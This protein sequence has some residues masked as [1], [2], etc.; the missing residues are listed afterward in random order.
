AAGGDD[1]TA[2]HL[3]PEQAREI[4][5]NYERSINLNPRH[6]ASYQNLAGIIGLVPAGNADDAKYLG[7]GWK[8]FP[9]D[10]MIRLGIAVVAK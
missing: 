7:V 9:D 3:T 5:N 8:L 10:G 2:R 4:A 6:R 1:G